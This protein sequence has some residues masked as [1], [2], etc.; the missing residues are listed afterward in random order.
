MIRIKQFESIFSPESPAPA[1]NGFELLL[2][3]LARS[4]IRPD[5]RPTDRPTVLRC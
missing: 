5:R 3:H 4:P 2:R 1:D